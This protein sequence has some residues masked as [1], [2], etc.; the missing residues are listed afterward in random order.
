MV[1]RQPPWLWV[2]FL[3]LAS[4]TT[5]CDGS[6]DVESSPT[7]FLASESPEATPDIVGEWLRAP[8][9]EEL[10][11]ALAREGLEDLAA[12][13]VRGLLTTPPN[14]PAKDAGHPCADAAG[15]VETSRLF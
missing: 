2:G 12:T 1:G 14:Q 5:G 7:P 9:C 11:R 4:L 8:T 3:A 10:V 6:S 13:S 15:P